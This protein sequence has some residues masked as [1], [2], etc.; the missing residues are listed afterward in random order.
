MCT[1]KSILHKAAQLAP[2]QDH[3]TAAP[4]EKIMG[5]CIPFLYLLAYICFFCIQVII[6]EP[7]ER[8]NMEKQLG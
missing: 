6:Q 1:K 5:F 3:N 2:Y 7:S 4:E 8:R